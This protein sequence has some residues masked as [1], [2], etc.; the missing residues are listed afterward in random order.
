MT[1]L[2]TPGYRPDVDGLRALAVLAV[3]A[4]HAFPAAAPGGSGWVV[5]VTRPGYSRLPR[6]YG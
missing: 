2:M 5:R 3:L 1:P 6:A 4:F